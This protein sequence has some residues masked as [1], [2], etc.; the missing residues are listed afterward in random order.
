MRI[1][2]CF[3]GQPRSFAK[4]FEYYKRNLFDHY[5]NV[6]VF[7][8]TWIPADVNGLI[9]LYQPKIC[10]IE[11]PLKKNFD[12]IYTNNTHALRFPSRNVVSSFYSIFKA[13][14]LKKDYEQ[15]NG[16]LYDWVIKTRFDYALNACIPFSQFDS[17]NMHIPD[18]HVWPNRDFGNDQFAFSSSENMDKYM[19]TYGFIDEF[20]NAG[21]DMTGENML[22]CNL[23]L[24]GLV[25]EN[26]VYVHMHN[27]F[28]PSE[29]GGWGSLIR[30]DYEEW[31]P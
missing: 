17:A 23:K 31:K 3:A 7:F 24:H 6:D 12:A 30:D 11:E 8:H 4:G 13:S 20:V 14:Q 2:L 29:L 26:L 27:P 15:Q 28:P 21:V 1:A 5:E 22:S 9:S 18:C 16:F 19:S 10:L 25:G